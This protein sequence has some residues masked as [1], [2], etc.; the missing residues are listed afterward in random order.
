MPLLEPQCWWQHLSQTISQTQSLQTISIL[1][2]ADPEHPM[3]MEHSSGVASLLKDAARQ[4]CL[5][6]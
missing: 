5:S 2:Y 1:N 3:V 6:D 4:A